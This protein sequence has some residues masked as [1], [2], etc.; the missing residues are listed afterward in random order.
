MLSSST[1]LMLALLAILATTNMA[2][3]TKSF[4]GPMLTVVRKTGIVRM[5]PLE[6]LEQHRRGLLKGKSSSDDADDDDDD[7]DDD[8]DSDDDEEEDDALVDLMARAEE[9]AKADAKE[10]MENQGTTEEDTFIIGEKDSEHTFSIGGDED[11]GDEEEDHFSVGDITQEGNSGFSVGVAT[12]ETQNG[13]SVGDR[14]T[15][16]SVGVPANTDMENG[17]W[18]GLSLCVFA[19][20]VLAVIV[21]RKRSQQEMKHESLVV[22]L[23]DPEA[24]DHDPEMNTGLSQKALGKKKNSTPSFGG[25]KGG[26][27]WSMRHSSSKASTRDAASPVATNAIRSSDKKPPASAFAQHD[28]NN[29]F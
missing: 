4:E 23:Q 13:F 3:T 15:G 29:N 17:L 19:F 12:D 22:N 14:G 11:E 20:V 25:A 21:A 28:K 18:I 6:V 16:F 1:T 5:E 9:D 8:D 2:A 27:I 26:S 10:A 24:D 7:E